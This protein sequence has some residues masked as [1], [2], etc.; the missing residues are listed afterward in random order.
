[1]QIHFTQQ[2]IKNTTGIGVKAVF[3]N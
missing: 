3:A 2:V 1:M